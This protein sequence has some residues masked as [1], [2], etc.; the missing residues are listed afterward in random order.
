M[1]AQLIFLS[2]QGYLITAELI[3]ISKSLDRSV[4]LL[5]MLQLLSV[6]AHVYEQ[7]FVY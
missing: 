6:S 3:F 7:M 5:A 2:F 4:P 1:C